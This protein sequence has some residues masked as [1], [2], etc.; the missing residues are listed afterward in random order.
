MDREESSTWSARPRTPPRRKRTLK[1]T[2]LMPQTLALRPHSTRSRRWDM[3]GRARTRVAF[4]SITL[5]L[6]LLP[7]LRYHGSHGCRLASGTFTRP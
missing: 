6:L 2:T 1:L 5:L 7:M 4:V 3:R